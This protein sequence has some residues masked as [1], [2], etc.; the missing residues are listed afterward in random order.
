G[1]AY[2]I[3]ST[4]VLPLVGNLV[5]ALGRKPVLVAFIIAFA[6]GSAISGSAQ[7]MSMLIAGRTVQGFGGGGC[8]GITEIIYAD[9]VPLPLRGKYQGIQASYGQ[10]DYQCRHS[11]AVGPPIGGALADSGA[12]RWLFFLN[13][14]LCGLAILLTFIL[15]RVHTS[16]GNLAVRLVQRDWM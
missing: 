8:M 11:S 7:N 13:L 4:A 2:T 1:S 10:G 15:I 9:L 6:I 16:R 12:W 5:S 3:A 14:P